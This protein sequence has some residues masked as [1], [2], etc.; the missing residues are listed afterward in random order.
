MLDDSFDSCWKCGTPDDGNSPRI[1][2]TSPPP[3]S[4]PVAENAERKQIPQTGGLD[5]RKLSKFVVGFGVVVACYGGVRIAMNLPL[6]ELPPAR[7]SGGATEDLFRSA[8]RRMENSGVQM[9]NLERAQER[10]EALKIIGVG[11][12]IIFA[13]CAVHLSVRRA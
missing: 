9:S 3:P 11:A 8:T 6:P 4:T 13:G 10:K 1:A 2:S 12:V 7:E 5:F